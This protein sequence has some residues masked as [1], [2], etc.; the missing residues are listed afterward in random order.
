MP[1][2]IEDPF[3]LNFED[4]QITNINLFDRECAPINISVCPS[5]D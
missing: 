3:A 1:E 5:S 4:I 2:M